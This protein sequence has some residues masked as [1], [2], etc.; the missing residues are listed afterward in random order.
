VSVVSALTIRSSVATAAADVRAGRGFRQLE[1]AGDEVFRQIGRVATA[2][3]TGRV[4]AQPAN[5]SL[6]SRS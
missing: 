2:T 3:R 5:H 1:D 4:L 6:T